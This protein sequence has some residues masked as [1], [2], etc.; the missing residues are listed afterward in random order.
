M[1]IR[2]LLG[3]ISFLTVVI[4]YCLGMAHASSDGGQDQFETRR[5]AAKVGG[6]C[7]KAGLA[8]VIDSQLE[9]LLPT[10]NQNQDVNGRNVAL[11]ILC[12]GVSHG[13]LNIA[14]D[15]VETNSK[16]TQGQIFKMLLKTLIDVAVSEGCHMAAIPNEQK[17]VLKALM[18]GGTHLL[19]QAP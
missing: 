1:R 18:H 4:L 15:A 10:R 5:M 12:K 2:N 3:K 17:Q 8:L 9:G 13:V 11:R 19:F 14:I 16:P 7:G 6:I